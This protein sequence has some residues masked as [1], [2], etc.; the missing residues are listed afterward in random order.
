[1]EFDLENP[2]PPSNDKFPS[3][4]HTETHH[5][6]SDTYFHNL[7]SETSHLSVR[8]E[9]VSSI[10]NYSRDFDSFLSYLAINYMDRFLSTQSI[11]DWKPWI[12]KLVSISCISLALKMRKIDFFFSDL[13][14]GD[15]GFMFNSHTIER[16]EMMILG[17]L[18]WRMRSVNP[19]SF[20]NYFISFFN[21][22][23]KS[24][25]QSLKNRATEI[26]LK[27][28]NDIKLLEFKPSIISG[29]ALLTAANE[30]FP[31][32]FP[33]FRDSICSCPYVDKGNLQHCYDVMKE[34][35]VELSSSI[36]CSE[37]N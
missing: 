16:M 18:N 12:F 37:W 32:Q 26:M 25:I 13:M 17:A 3:L 33:S 8:H 35:V 21:F 6:P 2:L 24:S 4:F 36:T 23:D 34:N 14:A 22:N 9:I 28:Q 30:L 20:N 31:V 11:R 27:G 7:I 19:F 1:M 10:F 15:G 5:M 29:A